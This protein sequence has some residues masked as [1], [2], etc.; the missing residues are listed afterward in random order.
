MLEIILSTKIKRKSGK[1][2]FLDSDGD[3]YEAVM[4]PR[5]PKYK[6]ELGVEFDIKDGVI[7]SQPT[8]GDEEDFLQHEMIKLS[9]GNLESTI[10]ILLCP[11]M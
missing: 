8:Y 3:L 9:N 5:I 10:N 4:G 7:W 2:Y 1:L 11:S 6:G